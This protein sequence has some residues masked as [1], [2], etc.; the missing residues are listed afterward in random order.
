[1]GSPV[2]PALQVDFLPAETSGNPQVMYISPQIQKKKKI[3]GL[4]LNNIIQ[5]KE[6][7]LKTIQ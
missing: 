4:N 2:S 1:M 5:I 6:N 7:D 3:D